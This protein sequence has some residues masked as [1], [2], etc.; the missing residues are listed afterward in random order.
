MTRRETYQSA[1]ENIRWS[2]EPVPDLW[3]DIDPDIDS[4]D[5]GPSDKGIKDQEKLDDKEQ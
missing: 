1:S 5:Y 2:Y 3:P 4:S